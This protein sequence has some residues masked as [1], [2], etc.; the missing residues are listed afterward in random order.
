MK[1]LV[2]VFILLLVV[3]CSRPAITEGNTM[4][5]FGTAEESESASDFALEK[6]FGEI[7]KDANGK[8]GV[9]TTVIETGQSA[10]LNASEHFAMQSV[11]KL[12]IAMAV[13]KQAGDG[14]IRL[15]DKIKV[16]KSEYVR[17]GQHSPIRDKFPNGAELTVR[18]L[19]EYAIKESD[20]TASDVLMRVAGGAAP[21]QKYV[22]DFGVTEM[23]IKNTE[24][25]IGEN[26]NV[27]YDNWS[28]PDGAVSLL[29]TLWNQKGSCPQG[30]DCKELLLFQDMYDSTPGANRLKGL[31]PK[32]TPVAHK[33][34]T[35]GT[36]NGI[37]AASNDIGIITMPNGNHIAIAVF[38]GD[39]SAD[40]KMR[41]AVIARIAKAA[42]DRWTA[43]A[44]K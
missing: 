19:I 24:K 9:A 11:Y 34:G 6:E 28:T 22:D 10:T 4:T 12:P 3:A 20:G 31:L 38:V 16:E 8:V 14:K 30:A 43:A 37:T 42:W 5:N 13:M 2:F 36:Q 32:G 26:W 1:L 39:S 18:E 7:A 44:P 21:I 27:Q 25:E 23:K 33:T 29:K 35:S 17:A 15:D 41:E 40:E